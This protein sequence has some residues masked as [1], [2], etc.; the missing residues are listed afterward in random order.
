[1]TDLQ[2]TRDMLNRAGIP[3]EEDGRADGTVLVTL[4]AAREWAAWV[5]F[6]FD[7]Q[8]ILLT[9]EGCGGED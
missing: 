5:E 9:A 1:M 8:G 3:F 6:L 4:P 7:K 2:M